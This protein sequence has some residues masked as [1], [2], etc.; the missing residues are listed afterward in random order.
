MYEQTI[1]HV[2]VITRAYEWRRSWVLAKYTR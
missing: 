2:L 1:I